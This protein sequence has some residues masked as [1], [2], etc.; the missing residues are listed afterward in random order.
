MGG[1]R[2]GNEITTFATSHWRK[3]KEGGKGG[4]VE[5][6]KEEEDNNN[7]TR[8]RK[9]IFF[10]FFIKI[11]LKEGDV[12]AKWVVSAQKAGAILTRVQVPG[13]ARDLSPTV[14][15]Q[16]RLSYGAR[17]ALVC[18]RLHRHLCKR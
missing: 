4:G 7:K 17:T 15:F 2:G 18:N 10:F 11:F 12:I 1:E 13:A 16:C 8:R 9:R 14:S 6:K 3:E 5:R